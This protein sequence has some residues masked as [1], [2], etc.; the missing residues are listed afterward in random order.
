[1]DVREKGHRWEREVVK[2]LRGIGYE[3][4]VTSRASNR[5]LDARKV[6]IDRVPFHI[7]CKRGY[8]RGINYSKLIKEMADAIR[9]EYGRILYPIIIMHKKGKNY[10]DNL[11]ILPFKDFMNIL[12]QLPTN[13][14]QGI[15]QNEPVGAKAT[16]TQP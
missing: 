4:A 1:M 11:V 10:E 14:I 13:D 6:D 7:Q 5:I 2:L 15:T 16:G 12:N 3:K 9:M 8:A